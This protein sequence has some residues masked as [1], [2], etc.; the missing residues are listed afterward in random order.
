MAIWTKPSGT[1]L[2]VLQENITTTVNLPVDSSAT[3]SLISGKLPPGLRLKG[4]QVFGTPKEVP[5]ETIFRFVLRAV[6]NGE[7]SDRTYSIEIQGADAPVWQTKEDLLQVGINNTYYVLDSSPVDFQLVAK[8]LDTSAGQRLRYFIGNGDGHLPPGITLTEDGRLVGVVDPILALEKEANRGEYDSEK[9]DRNPYDFSVKSSN[10]FDSFY[11]DVTDT[12]YD[13]SVPTNV[14][15]KLNRFYQFTVTV[16]DGDTTAR[17]QFRIYVVGDDFFHADTTIMQVGTGIFSADNTFIRTPIWLTPRDLGYRRS[18]N[19]VTLYLDI[20]DTNTLTGVVTY[21]LLSTNDDDSPSVLPPGMSLDATTGEIAGQIPYQPSITKEYKFTI[22]AKR[23]TANSLEETESSKT[24]IVKLLG[25]VDSTI[26]WS[27]SKSL[28]DIPANFISNLKVSANT[29]VPNATL[30]YT[31][32]DG[33]LPP[34]LDLQYDGEITGKI[35]SFSDQEGIGL[36][37][38]D[39]G[40]LVLDGNTTTIDRSYTFTVNARDQFGYS[41]VNK[42][43]TINVADPDDKFYSNIY[44]KP[45]LKQ[46]QRQEFIDFITN[47]AIIPPEDVYRPADPYFGLQRSINILLYS[48]IETVLAERYVSAMAKNTRRKLYRIG[49]L[50][51][52]V[53]KEPGTNNVLYEVVYLTV[54]DPYE[55]NGKVKKKINISTN[56]K[57]L[58]NSVRTTPNDFNYD[59]VNRLAI[60]IETRDNS[61]NTKYCDNFIEIYTREGMVQW[62]FGTSLYITTNDSGEVQCAFTRG[63]T[64]NL[65]N[66]PVP[67]NT[68]KVDSDAI[69]VSDSNK[70]VKYISNISNVRDEFRVL[71]RTERNFLPLWMRTAQQDSIQELGYIPAIPLVY[72]KPGTSETIA[73]AIR[74]SEFDYRQFELDI[75]RFL[76]D[77]TEGIGEPKYFV[78]ANYEFNL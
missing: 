70:I 21:E 4:T 35:R 43:F 49:E 19:Y 76:I 78:F 8:D 10:G 40:N 69:R 50:K 36:T 52:A 18:N 60:P 66:R 64:T 34:G 27:T 23:F 5:R 24:F 41:A 25:E 38:F 3:L 14:P 47:P 53:A 73:A 9:F 26:T 55:K 32:V 48:G 67:E 30:L 17:R 20:I 46:E 22:N 61:S 44:F 59:S 13:Y 33:R 12:K 65:F 29:S 37:I 77:S 11:Y 57:I 62:V 75:D 63:S 7:Q 2:A 54:I 71:G 74:F 42:T 6:L 56:E 1:K 15:R 68:I 31:L 51:T 16:S 58:V 45:L 72:C 28:G 39:T